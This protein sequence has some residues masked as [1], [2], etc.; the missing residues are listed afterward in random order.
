MQTTFQSLGE[1]PRLDLTL[2]DRQRF[3]LLAWFVGLLVFF[4][5][6]MLTGFPLWRR[7]RFVALT[8]VV[9]FALPLALPWTGVLS[10][11]CNAAFYA[12]CWLVPYYLAA[13]ARAGSGRSADRRSSQPQR[14]CQRQPP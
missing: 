9:S 11:V 5:G 10:P 2:V 1:V 14:Q 4:R 7:F 8:L 13:G 12:A 3:E 6:V